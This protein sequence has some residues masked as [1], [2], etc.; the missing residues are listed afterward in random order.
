MNLQINIALP[1]FLETLSIYVNVWG[2][3]HME[4]AFTRENISICI[5]NI[6]LFFFLS[7]IKIF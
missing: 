6:V 5:L 1:I 7:N 2:K 3:D 4:V